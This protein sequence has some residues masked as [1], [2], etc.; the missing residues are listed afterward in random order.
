MAVQGGK[1]VF[2][3]SNR[4]ATQNR[5]GANIGLGICMGMSC[6]WLELSLRQNRMVTSFDELGGFSV[7]AAQHL[8][9]VL[10][11]PGDHVEKLGSARALAQAGLEIEQT[12]KGTIDKGADIVAEAGKLQGFVLFTI[13]KNPSLGGPGAGG[14][15]HGMAFRITEEK[16][17]FFEPREGLYEFDSLEQM[18]QSVGNFLDRDNAG[19]KKGEWK[20]YPVS[21]LRNSWKQG[22]LPLDVVVTGNG[23]DM[24]ANVREGRTVPRQTGFSIGNRPQTVGH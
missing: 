2:R 5:A 18:K 13:K 23:I 11:K 3:S 9:Y 17:Y 16:C 22:Y 4:V 20:L 14:S 7:C 12:L 24:R 21:L 19:F 10:A 1:P 6:R 15:G 8:R